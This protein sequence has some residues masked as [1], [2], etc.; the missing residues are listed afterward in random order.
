MSST[1]R[2]NGTLAVTTSGRDGEA[3]L[4]HGQTADPE[5]KGHEM[6]LA[7][8]PLEVEKTLGGEWIL[9]YFTS[10]RRVDF[11]LSRRSRQPRD[12]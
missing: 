6:E 1:A 5:L 7:M 10:E 12:P 2:V 4:V 9:F 3:Y 8:R 11:R